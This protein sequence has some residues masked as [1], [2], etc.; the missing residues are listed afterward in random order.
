ML[1]QV[2]IRHFGF[3][4]RS[5]DQTRRFG[6]GLGA[7]L[8]P[9][10]VVLLEGAFGAGKTTLVQGLAVGAGASQ[11]V[12][13]PS[14]TLINEYRGRLPVFHVDLFRLRTLDVELE[15]ALE[16]CVS[17]DGATVVEWPDLLPADLREGA[18]RLDMR[19]VGDMER[20]VI[21]HTEGSRWDPGM[22]ESIIL[23]SL[24]ELANVEASP[25]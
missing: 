5:P 2:E 13:S 10:D 20:G 22:L 9:G 14:F 7:A 3:L 8:L 18:L 1:V 24:R 25:G 21:L 23:P 4:S 19:V 12:T 17:S 16:D 11:R 15:Q 6:A